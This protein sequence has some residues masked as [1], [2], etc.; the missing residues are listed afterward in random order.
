MLL[1]KGLG[2]LSTQVKSLSLALETDMC[3]LDHGDD[4]SVESVR[5]SAFVKKKGL[6]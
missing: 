5:S 2:E 1:C 6:A 4:F 3:T